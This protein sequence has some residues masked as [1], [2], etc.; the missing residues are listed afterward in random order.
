[1]SETTA[2]ESAPA[3][4]AETP[5]PAA[6]PRSL[7]EL[8]ASKS[9]EPTAPVADPATA[10][11]D[12]PAEP[13]PAEAAAEPDDAV[14][15]ARR[16]LLAIAARDRAARTRTAQITAREK[17]IAERE[18]KYSDVESIFKDPAK[19][20]AEA[21]KHGVTFDRLGRAV[22]GRDTAPEETPETALQRE[23]QELKTWRAQQ[24]QER[25]ETKRAEEQ[26]AAEHARGEHIRAFASEVERVATEFPTVAALLDAPGP[27][28]VRKRAYDVAVQAY[29]QGYTT[30]DGRYVPPGRAPDLRV[31]L[32]FVESE[33]ASAVN[34][35]RP[36]APA[37]APAPA[38]KGAKAEPAPT[39]KAAKTSGKTLTNQVSAK[40]ATEADIPLESAARRAAI[41]RKL[42]LG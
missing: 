36:P 38:Q 25:A 9:T 26:R 6:A 15:A 21:E 34:R 20:L 2:T 28:D 10:P 14:R 35:F 11:A 31:I 30:A 18:A 17:A 42:G 4:S 37:S 29:Q 40:P 12:A 23:L 22:L 1:M 33:Y 19:L 39:A 7:A 3:T 27:W 5:A 8:V 24:E 41:V 32:G 13:A 16:Q